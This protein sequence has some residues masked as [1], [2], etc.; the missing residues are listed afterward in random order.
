MDNVPR[1]L[2]RKRDRMKGTLKALRCHNSTQK[3]SEGLKV[4]IVPIPE[5]GPRDV[6]IDLKATGLCGSDIHFIDGSSILPKFP[7]TLGHET[8][9]FICEVGSEVWGFMPLRLHGCMVRV[10]SSGWMWTII[11]VSGQRSCLA[12]TR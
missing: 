9:G 12:P 8:A 1:G 10:W 7:T 2:R 11:C 6:L 3:I 4:E 5:I